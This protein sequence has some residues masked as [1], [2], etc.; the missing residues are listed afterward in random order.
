MR[1]PS[2]F[3]ARLGRRLRAV[4][5]GRSGGDRRARARRR[6]RAAPPGPTRTVPASPP[7]GCRARGAWRSS[8]RSSRSRR[9]PASS[10]PAHGAP[11]RPCRSRSATRGCSSGCPPEA[12]GG[13]PCCSPTTAASWRPGTWTLVAARPSWAA[14]RRVAVPGFGAIS[15]QAV[16]SP[17]VAGIPSGGLN[18]NYAGFERW[19]PDRRSIALV[20]QEA[21]PDHRRRSLASSSG[22]PAHRS[23]TAL[24]G[25]A[26]G[27][28][29]RLL[30]RGRLPAR[31]RGPA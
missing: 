4:R 16:D 25:D 7:R 6:P 14:P 22:G 2:T 15:I 24:T 20:D 26:R 1:D 29:R 31:R 11:R 3:E 19:S 18:T 23:A 27:R 9:S 12:A 17:A 5:G 10:P 28:D 8:R 13:R 30:L 21:R